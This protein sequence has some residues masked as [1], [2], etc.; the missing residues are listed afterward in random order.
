MSKTIPILMYHSL[1]T[2][3]FKGK[4]AISKRL[5]EKQMKFL[6]NSYQVITLEESIGLKSQEGLFEGKV[7][8][9]FDDGE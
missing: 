6:A 2:E 7:V 8:L 9:S 3:R 5:F 4:T 1:D